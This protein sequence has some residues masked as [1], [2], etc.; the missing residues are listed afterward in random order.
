MEVRTYAFAKALRC[1]QANII[2]LAK[3]DP[4]RIIRNSGGMIDLREPVNQEYIRDHD[5]TVEEVAIRCREHAASIENKR[6]KI[7]EKKESERRL[8]L[9][10][11]S[12]SAM[13]QR[14]TEVEEKAENERKLLIT[15]VIETITDEF[16]SEKAGIILKQISEKIA[17]AIGDTNEKKT[18]NS[19]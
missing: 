12:L 15:S 1:S 8:K 5:L 19:I 7:D 4:P 9:D 18:K 6:K 2:Q 13:S 3:K 17:K 16:G 11:K 10:R 14:L